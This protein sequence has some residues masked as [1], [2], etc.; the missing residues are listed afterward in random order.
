MIGFVAGRVRSLP[1]FFG[2]QMVGAIGE[3]F[4][5][6]RSRGG[7][8]VCRV[9]AHAVEWFRAQGIRRIELQVVSRQP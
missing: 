8:I 1:P 4:V 2:S 9:L 6:E 7:G 5:D 3:L